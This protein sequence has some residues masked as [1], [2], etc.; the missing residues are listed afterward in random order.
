MDSIIFN[1]PF[2]QYII[3]YLNKKRKSRMMVLP[4]IYHSK[5]WKMKI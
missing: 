1:S 2:K 3:V 5:E 4:M